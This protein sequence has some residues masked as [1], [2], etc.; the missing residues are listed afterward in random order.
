[1]RPSLPTFKTFL[2]TGVGV[3]WGGATTTMFYSEGGFT[4]L[5]FLRPWVGV[6]GRAGDFAPALVLLF[7]FFEF[8]C[9]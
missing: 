9:K 2:G 6:A 7:L 1:M 4:V 8:I 3:L 5:L